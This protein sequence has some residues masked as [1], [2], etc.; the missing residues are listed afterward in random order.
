M[1]RI[2][3]T[4]V[5]KFLSQKFV[6]IDRVIDGIGTEV[7]SKI[8]SEPKRHFHKSIESSK[9]TEAVKA[10]FLPKGSK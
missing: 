6:D 2:G 3:E 4:P 9:F 7:E 8:T 1:L 5:K 10:K